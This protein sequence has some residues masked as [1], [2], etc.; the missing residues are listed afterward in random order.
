MKKNITVSIIT[1]VFNDEKNILKTVKSVCDQTFRDLEYILIDGGSTDATVDIFKKAVT[2]PSVIVS[3]ND[4]GI[5]DAM[6]KGIKIAKGKW[7]YLLNSG[8]TLADNSVLSEFSD[9][10]YRC[11]DTVLYGN[12]NKITDSA[13]IKISYEKL[14]LNGGLYQMPICHQAMFVCKTIH[15]VVGYYDTQWLISA[16]FDFLLR[17]VKAGA[18]TFKFQDRQIVNFDFEGTSSMS[19]SGPVENLKIII[20]NKFRMT[21]SLTLWGVYGMASLVILSLKRYLIFRKIISLK[22]KIFGH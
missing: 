5:Y 2:I 7:I 6:N 4:D 16:D 1:V 9:F 14:N 10:F 19:T 8:D 12:A 20:K 15:D 13:S 11:K 21:S 18:F 22:H 3:E 17:V